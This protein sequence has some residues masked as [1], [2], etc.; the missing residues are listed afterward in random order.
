MVVRRATVPRFA[1]SIPVQEVDFHGGCKFI[2]AVSFGGNIKSR[3]SRIIDLQFGKEL[4]PHNKS[5]ALGK[6]CAVSFSPNGR[7]LEVGLWQR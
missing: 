1:S 6:I 2:G 3:W 4:Y 7:L 5:V